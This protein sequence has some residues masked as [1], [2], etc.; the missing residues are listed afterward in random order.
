MDGWRQLGLQLKSLNMCARWFG[1]KWNDSSHLRT[2]GDTETTYFFPSTLS[3]SEGNVTQTVDA[4]ALTPRTARSWAKTELVVAGMVRGA[5]GQAM[6]AWML[7]PM[8]S[9]QP[10]LHFLKT[11]SLWT[12]D[13]QLEC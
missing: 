13:L 5:I 8:G 12:L 3:A 10:F 6:S 9:R 2:L 1:A 7:K 11:M 4:N